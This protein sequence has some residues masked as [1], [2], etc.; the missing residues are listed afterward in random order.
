[1]GR[2]P[3]LSCKVKVKIHPSMAMEVEGE[4]IYFSIHSL[5]QAL[6]R[7]GGQRHT[8]PALPPGKRPGT[9]LQEAGWDPGPVWTG[10]ENFVPTGV[11][12]PDRPTRGASHVFKDL[13]NPK[14]F[15]QPQTFCYFVN[16]V[17]TVK[18]TRRSYWCMCF[19]KSEGSPEVVSWYYIPSSLHEVSVLARN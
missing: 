1:M 7:V 9:H 17:M 2:R 3:G 14:E 19:T 13:P 4:Q 10:A 12:T 15:I 6:D 11:R 5:T 18:L 16:I 8:P